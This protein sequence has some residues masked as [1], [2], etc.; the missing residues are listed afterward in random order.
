M[1]KVFITRKLAGKGETLLREKGFLLKVFEKDRPITPKEL[2]KEAADA[3]AVISLLTD[4]ID[5]RIIDSLK[6]CRV[7]ANCAVGYNNIDVQYARSKKIIVTNTPDI[8]TDA[9]ADLTI[10]LILACARRLREGE[11]MMR[12]GRFKSWKPMLLLGMELSGKTAGIIGAG[13]IG[14]AVSKRLN[15]F[16]TKII[17]YDRNKREKLESE[18]NAVKV[19]LETLLKNSDIVS[20]HIPLSEETFH[21]LNKNNL[22]LMKGNSILVNTSRG[23]IADEKFLIRMLRN[24]KIF[25]AGLDVYEGEPEINP[26]LLKLE[27]VFLLPHIGSATVETRS[28]MAELCARN[29]IAVLEGKKALTPV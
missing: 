25:A 29:V 24:G 22:K 8:L 2:L 12:K 4:R 7:I 13:R 18:F 19:T 21:L 9:T 10:A 1:K 26:E 5:S 28:G 17:Y 11:S 3:D 20:I 14:Y 23:E 15:S 27:N 16:G 6:K